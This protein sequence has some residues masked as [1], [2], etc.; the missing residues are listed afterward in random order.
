MFGR[1]GANR[2]KAT[3][4]GRQREEKKSLPPFTFGT[5]SYISTK[6]VLLLLPSGSV[7]EFSTFETAL[8]YLDSARQGGAAGA[9]EARIFV[10]ESG[11]WVERNDSGHGR[12]AATS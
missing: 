10:F 7:I 3:G 1:S 9:H 5:C 2:G 8:A 11:A 12:I 4:F 6:P